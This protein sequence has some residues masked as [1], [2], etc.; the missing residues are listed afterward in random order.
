[1]TLRPQGLICVDRHNEIA[2]NSHGKSLVV[3]SE[4]PLFKLTGHEKSPTSR[5][6]AHWTRRFPHRGCPFCNWCFPCWFSS[7]LDP[8]AGQKCG[9]YGEGPWA[10]K[11]AAWISMAAGM[12]I[13]IGGIQDLAD[14]WFLFCTTSYGSYA[15]W[16][17]KFRS[18]TQKQPG[19]FAKWD[20]YLSNVLS[21]VHC[22]CLLQLCKFCQHHEGNLHETT[23]RLSYSFYTLGILGAARYKVYL[24]A[25]VRGPTGSGVYSLI[26]G[27][28][29]P[30]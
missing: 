10:T 9:V 6:F 4:Y 18:S 27:T 7:S 24:P 23:I 1:M 8:L 22:L 5:W 3:L 26:L 30:R 12:L 11:S 15:L 13:E 25:V 28:P 14:L 19:A 29:L 2:T 21:F 17:P 16:W 20:K